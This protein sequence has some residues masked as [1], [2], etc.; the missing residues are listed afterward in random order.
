[1]Q[2]IIYRRGYKEIVG[3]FNYNEKVAVVASASRGVGKGIAI[4]LSKIGA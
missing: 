4:S 2:P 3:R 1:M